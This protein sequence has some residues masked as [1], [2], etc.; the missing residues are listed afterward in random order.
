MSGIEVV[1]SFGIIAIVALIAIAV[2]HFIR[3]PVRLGETQ[4]ETR[5]IIESD[6]STHVGKKQYE[7][8]VSRKQPK[9]KQPG[10]SIPV[11]DIIIPDIEETNIK[12][13]TSINLGRLRTSKSNGI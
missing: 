13:R 7:G 3:T 12:K 5:I 1:I 10:I 4:G 2:L 9:L 6:G 11:S 8:E